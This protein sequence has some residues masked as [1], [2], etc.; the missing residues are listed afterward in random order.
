MRTL[1]LITILTLG[2][3]G[4]GDKAGTPGAGGGGAG[5][6]T[7][8]VDASTPKGVVD[9]YFAAASSGDKEG[10]LSLGTPEWREKEANWQ[11]GFT[12]HIADKGWRPKVEQMRGPREADD[13]T[14]RISVKVLFT[15][16]EGEENG[17]GMSFTL[18][19]DGDR[20]WIKDLR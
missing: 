3:T 20:Y 14:I 2:L 18:I 11:K 1:A 4:C 12:L 7:H 13:G 9:A 16:P 6:A 5:E 10:M 19:K 15:N 8:K 17:E